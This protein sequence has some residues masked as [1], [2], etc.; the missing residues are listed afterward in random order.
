MWHCRLSLRVHRRGSVP[1]ADIPDHYKR[2]GKCDR[3]FLA[4][5][6]NMRLNFIRAFETGL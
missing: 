3:N 6:S 1:Q 2:V 4:S 5:A